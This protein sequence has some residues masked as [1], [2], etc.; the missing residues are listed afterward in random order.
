LRTSTGVARLV[1]F[2]NLAWDGERVAQKEKPAPRRDFR[3]FEGYRAFLDGALRRLA[4]N[5]GSPERRFPFHFLGTI[6]SGY[7]STAIAVLARDAGLRHVVSF[8]HADDHGWDSGRDI[9]R[10]LDLD[11]TVIDRDA[12][13]STT[14]PEIPFLAADA[15]GEDVYFSSAAEHLHG[16]VLLTGFHGDRMWGK[17]THALGPDLVRGDQSGLSLTEFRLRAGFLHCPVPFMG[18]QQIDDVNRLSWSDALA[19]WDIRTGYSRPICRRIV[20]EAGIP[21]AAFGIHKKASSILFANRST[22][23]TPRTLAEY[24]PWLEVNAGAWRRPGFEPPVTV[25]LRRESAV[26]GAV[27]CFSRVIRSVAPERVTRF[28]ST[29]TERE[30]LFRWVFPWALERA[31]AAYTL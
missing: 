20:E 25:P 16:A 30:P 14:L 26:Q 27:A 10:R 23:L 18:V 29:W 3:T 24:L 1:Y 21:R 7:D 15:K 13:R 19:R 4:G 31:R 28:L 22:F 2:K 11:V 9:A 12:W 8:D 5:L 6:S 17:Y